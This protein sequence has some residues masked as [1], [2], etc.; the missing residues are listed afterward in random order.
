MSEQL[1]V[2]GITANSVISA[3][4]V[5]DTL[6]SKLRATGW[7]SDPRATLSVVS[8]GNGGLA[9]GL[10]VY[11]GCNNSLS[12]ATNA[13]KTALAQTGILSNLS[14]KVTGKDRAGCTIAQTTT[15]V[16]T[17]V[18][19]NGQAAV[20]QIPT[21]TIQTPTNNT[22]PIAPKKSSGISD[23]AATVGISVGAL[24]GIGLVFV[25]VVLMPRD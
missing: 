13:L 24:L 18:K 8:T 6:S 15:P 20:T 19:P 12:E 3:E 17:N 2:F 25:G 23:F 5:W 16:V 22:N 7:M 1:I 4:T 14:V 21:N 10:A 11:F 9:I